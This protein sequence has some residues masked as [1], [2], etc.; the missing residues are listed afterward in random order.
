M[1]GFETVAKPWGMNGTIPEDYNFSLLDPDWDHFKV[2]WENAV[3]TACP[4]M[5]RS[6]DQPVLCQCRELHAGQPLPDGRGAG[7]EE[8]LSRHRTELHRHRRR[9]RA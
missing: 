4:A 8:L 6:G 2:F 1:G 3:F 9:A 7:A 5:E